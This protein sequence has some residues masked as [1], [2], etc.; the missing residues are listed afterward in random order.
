MPSMIS[1][2]GTALI[3][4]GLPLSVTATDLQDLFRP[5]GLVAWVR[6]ATDRCGC[7]LRYGYVVMANEADAV[8]AMKAL[9]GMPLAGLPMTIARTVYPPL[10]HP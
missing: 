5:F 3:V 10:P 2:I 8:L 1:Q 9:N 4:D 7:S 6:L